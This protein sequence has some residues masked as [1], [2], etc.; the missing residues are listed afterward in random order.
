MDAGLQVKELAEIIG[1]TP[2]TVINWEMR[3]SKPRGRKIRERIRR[4]LNVPVAFE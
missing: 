3:G 4:L 2:D 1:V